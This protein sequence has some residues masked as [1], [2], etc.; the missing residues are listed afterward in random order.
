M[1]S[2]DNTLGEKAKVVIISQA[3]AEGL[4]LK[5][6]RQV[7]I[8]E[9]WYNMSRIEQIIGR[10]VRTCSHKALPFPSRNVQIFLY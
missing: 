8:M 7:H 4:D 3:G 5:Y 6:V 9:P 1:T 2:S 10:A